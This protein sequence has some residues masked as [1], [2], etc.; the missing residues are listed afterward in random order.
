MSGFRD[1]SLAEAAEDPV[2]LA[3]A[4]LSL[5]VVSLILVLGVFEAALRLTA[6]RFEYPAA[7]L[8]EANSFRIWE[9]PPNSS[10]SRAHPVTGVRHPIIYNNL[11]LRQ[12]R[13]IPPQKQAGET[14]IGFFGDS[15]TENLR[16]PGPLQFT[17]VLDFLLTHQEGS[18][19]VLNFGVAGYGTDQSYLYYRD[20]EVAKDL[21]HVFYVFHWNDVLNLY[22]NDLFELTSSGDLHQKL[23]RETPWWRR[24][25]AR[26]YT[27]YLILEATQRLM[28]SPSESEGVPQS[29]R[30]SR[31][32]E[33]RGHSERRRERLRDDLASHLLDDARSGS[34]SERAQPYV[35]LLRRIVREWR[36]LAERRGA[37]FH[38]VITPNKWNCDFR[39]IF[40][41]DDHVVDLEEAFRSHGLGLSW[42]FK[43]DSHWNELGNQ[44]AAVHLLKYLERADGMPPLSRDQ[45]SSQL[46]VFYD[47]F[48]LGWKPELWVVPT[49]SSD[50]ARAQIRERYANLEAAAGGG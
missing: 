37:H 2:K 11:A 36:E 34:H 39:W 22:Q 26:F 27:T 21:D 1:S 31:S 15:F 29:S 44:L 46:F 9:R 28:S 5:A 13:D 48:D 16:I 7:S 45:I 18:F 40:E 50:R 12:N 30:S 35:A 20:A 25:L 19:T 10:D 23:A 6:P 4:K 33:E 32:A 17:E 43:Q 47:A 42:K 41:G 8:F 14:R 24:T 38:I 49:E 3:W